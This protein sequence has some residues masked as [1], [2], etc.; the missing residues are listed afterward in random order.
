MKKYFRAV[1]AILILTVLS[2]GIVGCTFET[3]YSKNLK[4]IFETEYFVCIN[5]EGEDTVTILTLTDKG[6]EQEIL[7]IPDKING[8]KVNELGGQIR[9][10]VFF[11]K[12]TY[13]V[14]FTHT[15]KIYFI[16]ESK[17]PYGT[18]HYSFGR[19]IPQLVLLIP[20]EALLDDLKTLGSDNTYSYVDKETLV[21]ANL[22]RSKADLCNM[23]FYE[24]YEN[25]RGMP[26]WID[27][28]CENGVYVKPSNPQR[29]GYVFSGW[30]TD[31]D[32]TEEWNGEYAI[33]EGETSL[34]LYAKW[35]P[36]QEG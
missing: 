11:N 32:G 22:D 8:Y 13:V 17:A 2:G 28:I 31:S 12:P 29:T 34:E 26:Y 35:I 15:K 18:M 3:Q 24:N 33:P 30:Y 20:E 4:R 23:F 5:Y 10:D 27:Y 21:K 14:Q 19:N 36:T 1:L 16:K 25:G 7:V 6:K 9:G